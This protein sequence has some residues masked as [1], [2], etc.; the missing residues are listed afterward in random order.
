MVVAAEILQT[1]VPMQLALGEP[2]TTSQFMWCMPNCAVAPGLKAVLIKSDLPGLPSWID[3]DVKFP[4]VVVM[5]I[6]EES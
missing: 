4:I 1:P 6:D 2:N 5:I 3:C